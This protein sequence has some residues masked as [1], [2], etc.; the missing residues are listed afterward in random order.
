MTRPTSNTGDAVT[1]GSD[2]PRQSD[3]D[4]S[5]DEDEDE[6]EEDG[7]DEDEEQEEEEGKNQPGQ[8]ESIGLRGGSDQPGQSNSNKPEESE[9]EAE[10]SEGEDEESEDEKEKER[11]RNEKGK[12]RK[13]QPAEKSPDELQGEPRLEVE[14][15]PGDQGTAR[16][17]IAVERL[18]PLLF[19]NLSLAEKLMLQ[20]F[21]AMTLV[22]ELAVCYPFP[23]HMRNCVENHLA[24]CGYEPAS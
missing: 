23:C 10:E 19:G 7:E 16:I 24:R 8:S 4:R 21:V 22:H 12:E 14:E 17:R 18:S 11:R 3:S 9:D 6:D 5:E 1:I 13:E 20:L 15:E 2:Q